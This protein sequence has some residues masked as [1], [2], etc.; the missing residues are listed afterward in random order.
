MKIT[1]SQGFKKPTDDTP[2]PSETLLELVS[3]YKSLG[4]KVKRVS[5]CRYAL[6]LPKAQ[7][8][9]GTLYQRESTIFIKYDFAFSEIETLMPKTL[10]LPD[11]Q[12]I[13]E[14]FLG[15]RGVTTW[16]TAI[17]NLYG[18]AINRIDYDAKSITIQLE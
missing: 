13:S 7:M 16:V 10:I 12:A 3:L 11:A 15:V 18:I 1:N 8:C 9:I 14:G 2:T 4:M 6:T 5:W 17:S